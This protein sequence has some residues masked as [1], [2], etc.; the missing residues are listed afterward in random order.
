MSSHPCLTC[1]TFYTTQ[2][3]KDGAQMDKLDNWPAI[4]SPLSIE[5]SLHLVVSALIVNVFST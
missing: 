3:T 4:G 5:G 2:Q 1:T